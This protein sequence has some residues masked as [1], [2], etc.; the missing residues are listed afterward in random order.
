MTR[1]SVSTTLM[2]RATP[3]KMP[4]ASIPS[5]PLKKAADVPDGPSPATRPIANPAT[6]SAL[7]S[8]KPQS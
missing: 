8:L 7:S 6:N 2:A 5:I 1:P 3:K 4:A